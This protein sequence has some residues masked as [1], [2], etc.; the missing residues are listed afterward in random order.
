MRSSWRGLGDQAAP[1]LFFAR[2]KMHQTGARP[3]VMPELLRG[4]KTAQNRPHRYPSAQQDQH[5]KGW[6]TEGIGCQ[7]WKE[8]YPAQNVAQRSARLR[9]RLASGANYAYVPGFLCKRL[10]ARPEPPEIN[11]KDHKQEPHAQAA[12]GQCVAR[13]AQRIKQVRRDEDHAKH[14]NAFIQP[15]RHP[16][17][18]TG[19]LK[20]AGLG[21]GRWDGGAGFGKSRHA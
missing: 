11:T 1:V 21:G 8:P 10:A 4:M 15:A 5:F 18:D 20:L 13:L 7:G 6:Y 14:Q 9:D 17:R 19:C 12:V 16:P 3:C 2:I